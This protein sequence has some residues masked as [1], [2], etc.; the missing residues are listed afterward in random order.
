MTKT[1]TEHDLIR[2]LYRETTE[3]EEKQINN[4]LICDSELLALYNQISALKKNLEGAVLEPS[5]QTVLSILNYA[6]GVKTK[7]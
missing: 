2:Y 7:D 3:K 5:S 4:A 6:R 1:F